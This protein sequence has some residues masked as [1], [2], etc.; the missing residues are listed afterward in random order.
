MAADRYAV[1]GH[2]IAYSRSPQI[3]ARFAAQCRQALDY[4][5]VDAPADGFP[6]AARA[7][8]DAGGRGLNV[9]VPFKQ[10]AFAFAGTLTPRAHDAGAVNTLAMLADGTLLGDNTDGAGLVRDLRHNLGCTLEGARVLLL[11]AGGA[12]HGVLLPLLGA[13]VA[14]IVIAN[15]TQERAQR[16]A[17][18]FAGRGAVHALGDAGAGQLAAQG[19]AGFELV[20]NATA[21][22]TAGE[23]PDV[24]E[25]AIGSATL[26]YDIGYTQAQSTFMR[27]AR[28]AG[29]ART[30]NGL[31]MLV[32]QAAE[33]FLLWRGVRPNTTPVLE[34]LHAAHAAAD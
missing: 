17:A 10:E 32:E 18:Q 31:G 12:A 33:S 2:R 3:H 8:F 20:I 15:R 34:A 5:I 29:A 6:A 16:L 23:L 7:F 22:S 14:G 26:A 30:V 9:T 25:H 24:P 1:I 27:W 28:A 21:A 13:G 11:G 19:P 4:G